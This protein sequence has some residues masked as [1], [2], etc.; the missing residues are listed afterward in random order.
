MSGDWGSAQLPGPTKPDGKLERQFTPTSPG[1]SNRA[2][3]YVEVVGGNIIPSMYLN[4]RLMNRDFAGTHA[5]VDVT[6]YLRWGQPNTVILNL[7]YPSQHSAVKTV[8]LRYYDPGA[9]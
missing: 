2:M 9:F 6:P 3:F 4:G 5:L 8:E 1:N 7:M